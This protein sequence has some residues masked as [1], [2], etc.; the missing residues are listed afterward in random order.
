[1]KILLPWFAAAIL[2]L[3]AQL[4]HAQLVDDYEF[5]YPKIKFSP[6]QPV[7]EGMTYKHT[8]TQKTERLK[9]EYLNNLNP[10]LPLDLKYNRKN[11]DVT[12]YLNVSGINITGIE[13]ITQGGRYFKKLNY[14][15]KSSV[16]CIDKNGATVNSLITEDGKKVKSVLVG[17]S[18][19]RQ[20]TLDNTNI[21]NRPTFPI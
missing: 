6:S 20:M 9:E 10:L 13:T 4:T 21:P 16:D 3:A 15:I 19:F 1:M 11:P 12:F 5:S 14:T 2:S 8:H 17:A 7:P 18:F